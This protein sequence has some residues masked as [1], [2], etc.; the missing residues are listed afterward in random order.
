VGNIRL[1][2][3]SKLGA[4]VGPDVR[5]VLAAFKLGKAERGSIYKAFWGYNSSII[6]TISQRP[7][8]YLEPKDARQA[9][10][11]WERRGELLIVERARLSTY[12][13][14]AVY[15][16]E[17]V[18]SN[19]WWPVKLDNET[20]KILAL[21]MN[22]TLGFLLLSSMAEVTH[23]PWVKFKKEYL[24]EMPVLDINALNDDQKN[25][26][27]QLY[28]NVRDLRFRALPQE[29]ADPSARKVIDGEISRILG[30][31]LRLEALYELLSKEPM[32]TG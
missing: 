12:T 24:L 29:F 10:N 6:N 25:A 15:L 11:L 27:L 4:E 7:N 30:L 28:D 32:L 21:W 18:L 23:G 1:T 3:L 19:V 20:A 22:S 26:F 9:R 14:L 13:V 5:Q 16:D 2:T 17:G 31:K 8:A